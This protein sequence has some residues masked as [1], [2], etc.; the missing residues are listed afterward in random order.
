MRNDDKAATKR[1][2]AFL[3]AIAVFV[4]LAVFLAGRATAARGITHAEAE[5]LICAPER[6]ANLPGAAE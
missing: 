1:T 6:I 5:S 2:L 3:A 4:L